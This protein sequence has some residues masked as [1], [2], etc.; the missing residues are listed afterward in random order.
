MVFTSI[1]EGMLQAIDNK[2]QYLKSV[3]TIFNDMLKCTFQHDSVF[4][5]SLFEI[6]FNYSDIDL[7]FQD[8]VRCK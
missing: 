7:D 6:A 5:E 3:K 4:L 8:I 2:E 1:F